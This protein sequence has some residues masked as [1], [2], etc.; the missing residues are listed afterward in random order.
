MKI[1]KSF[2]LD[3]FCI[4]FVLVIVSYILGTAIAETILKGYGCASIAVNPACSEA[5]YVGLFFSTCIV[6]LLIAGALIAPATIFGF[7]RAHT[8]KY[9]AFA[10][11]I[12]IIELKLLIGLISILTWIVIACAIWWYQIS[13]IKGGGVH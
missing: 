6:M 10:E 4:V 11:R 13:V 1:P 8:K 5:Y 12:K 7:M 9:A 2:W 3:E